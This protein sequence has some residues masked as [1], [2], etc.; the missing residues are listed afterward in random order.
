MFLQYNG[1]SALL[2]YHSMHVRMFCGTVKKSR[3]TVFE[4]KTCISNNPPYCTVQYSTGGF[5][6]VYMHACHEGRDTTMTGLNAIG[7][8]T[9]FPLLLY[10]YRSINCCLLRLVPPSERWTLHTGILFWHRHTVQLQ[11][12]CPSN[13]MKTAFIAHFN[14]QRYEKECG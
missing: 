9:V 7:H 6:H 8:S 10:L 11:C 14:G 4:L 5:G 3:P 2:P 13:R 12:D 1:I